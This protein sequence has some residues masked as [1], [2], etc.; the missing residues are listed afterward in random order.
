LTQS[1]FSDGWKPVSGCRVSRPTAPG[2]IRYRCSE[3]EEEN[4]LRSTRNDPVTKDPFEPILKIVV[5]PC[6]H[7][8]AVAHGNRWRLAELRTLLH[9]LKRQHHVNDIRVLPAAQLLAHRFDVS[10]QSLA[11]GVDIFIHIRPIHRRALL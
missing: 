11:R 3:P 1:G 4:S 9:S 2:V 10:P 5:V 7:G 6:M 8:S